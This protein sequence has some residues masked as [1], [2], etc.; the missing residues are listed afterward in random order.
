MY[1]D[2]QI[3]NS[4]NKI[5]TIWIIVNLET[6]RNSNN[7]AIES[8]NIDGRIV[9][10]EQHMADTFNNYFLSIADNININDN[11]THTQNK[12]NPNSDNNNIPL[13]SVSQFHNSPYTNIKI[14]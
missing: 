6:H 8:L 2:N 12:Y 4:T 9:N 10:N 5:K 14:F 13:Q 7:A 3:T 11:N 1:Y